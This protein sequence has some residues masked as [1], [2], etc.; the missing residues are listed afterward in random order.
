MAYICI[1]SNIIIR[2]K[3]Y[4]LLVSIKVCYGGVSLKSEKQLP[5]INISLEDFD[6]IEKAYIFE[7]EVLLSIRY[8]D[9]DKIKKLYKKYDSYESMSKLVSHLTHRI[10]GDSLMFHKNNTLILNSL[11]RA[12]ARR[13][14]L[15]N[16]YLHLIFEK[17]ALMIDSATT[18]K[19]LVYTLQPIICEEY[20]KAVNLFS[21]RGYSTLIKNT[22]NYITFNVSHYITIA[23]LAKY[24]NVNPST[25]SRKFKKETNMSITDYYNYQRI[26]LAK[27]YFEKGEI[28]ISKVSHKIGFND[29]SYFT[30][31]FKKVAGVLPKTYISNI[32][33]EYARDWNL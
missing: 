21:T 7:E 4:L 24:F 17:F 6:I 27:Y 13:G 12:A 9:V 29:S 1:L 30:K 2:L 22:I 31:V 19:Y 10:P 32:K 23:E 16:V 26:E 3:W 33:A 25:L 5:E 28:N 11:S 15:P 14:G 8:G 20:A 18:N